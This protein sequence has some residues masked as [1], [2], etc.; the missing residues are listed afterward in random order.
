MSTVVSVNLSC[1]FVL[2]TVVSVIAIRH[3]SHPSVVLE[4][5]MNVHRDVNRDLASLA[6]SRSVGFVVHTDRS[7]PGIHGTAGFSNTEHLDLW[8]V[9]CVLNMQKYALSMGCANRY[10]KV[11]GKHHIPAIDEVVQ[12]QNAC[13]QVPKIVHQKLGSVVL[14]H[15][16]GGCRK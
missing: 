12:K 5:M 2:A 15:I 7:D 13:N 11:V 16:A 1:K 8:C 4:T 10:Q 14:F 3:T 6:R 9:C